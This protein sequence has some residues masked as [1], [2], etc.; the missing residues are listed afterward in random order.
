MTP[1][2]FLLACHAPST[3]PRSRALGVEAA[4]ETAAPET[5]ATTTEPPL[6]WG[7]TVR[8]W[9]S[10]VPKG[11]PN[12]VPGVEY[13]GL[14]GVTL[15]PDVTGDHLPEIIFRYYDRS[16]VV[17]GMPER[18][19]P[20][21]RPEGVAELFDLTGNMVGYA[22]DLNGDG[23]GDLWIS[24]ALY[25]G[26][27]TLETRE[28]KFD[29]DLTVWGSGTPL[30]NVDVDR[31]GHLDVVLSTADMALI[32]Q[33]G[34]F[35]EDDPLDVVRC[36]DC[37][38]IQSWNLCVGS[39]PRWVGPVNH[40][41]E[42]LVLVAG[43]ICGPGYLFDVAGERGP[44]GAFAPDVATAWVGSIQD[45]AINLRGD[46][47]NSVIHYG[48]IAEE[49]VGPIV[50]EGG[51]GH[52]NFADA[53]IF[54][55]LGDLTGDGRGE[56]MVHNWLPDLDRNEYAVVPGQGDLLMA[57]AKAMGVKLDVRPTVYNDVST[58]DLDGDGLVEVV[59]HYH[60]QVDIFRGAD[61]RQALIDQGKL[62]PDGSLP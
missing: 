4:V 61:I 13:S 14:K 41:D 21:L 48:R 55:G 45:P 18:G 38:F 11:D 26:P 28:R 16:I 43:G 44:I 23:I 47:L 30:G 5:P 10:F 42:M 19:V 20:D 27:I 12:Y 22:G 62:Q 60:L 58:L 29:P 52:E 8:P 35:L 34:P 40:P 2:T 54:A 46:G 25:Y 31:D 57:P 39:D 56:L 36:E 9:A 1:F 24:A 32:V 59:A 49:A 6:D 53:A 51:P 17:S 7:Q 50:L 33:Y 15:V 37:T 3:D